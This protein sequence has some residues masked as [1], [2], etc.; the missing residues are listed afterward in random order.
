MSYRAT[1]A[2][3]RL[4]PR[5]SALLDAMGQQLDEGL[6][7]LSIYSDPEIYALELERIYGRCWV[8]LGHESEIP[9]PGDYV[10][11]TI[12]E[13]PWIVVRDDSGTVHVLFN[14]CR[15]R[16]TQVCPADQGNVSVF[17]CPY[18]GW[19]YNNAG[20]LVV[21]PE[22]VEAY[23]ALDLA[24]WGLHEAPQIDSYHGLIFACL[25]PLAPSLADYLGDFR[26]YM[27]LNFGMARAGMEVVGEPHRWVM[28]GDW[29]SGAE[30]FSGDPYHTHSLH[31]S[32][33]FVRGDSVR[34]PLGSHPNI[35]ECSGHGASII[36]S[37]P[38]QPGFFAYPP[39]VV[40]LLDPQ[41]VTPAQWDLASR[42]RFTF[43]TVFPNLSWVHSGGPDPG[44]KPGERR[45][46]YLSFRQW[47]PRGPGRIEVWSWV[48]VPKE[49]SDE[50]KE[51]SYRLAVSRFGPSGNMEQDDT[52]VWGSIARAARTTYAR[53]AQLKINL[54][55]GLEGMSEAKVLTDWPGPGLV[56][57]RELE[58]G[59]QR[60]ILRHWLAEMT[61]P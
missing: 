3:S 34:P 4:S 56:Y 48:L 38:D 30:N 25:D 44:G 35:A 16:G 54:Q 13:D 57:D 12:G 8:C 55:M 47:Q 10:L 51:R 7:P 36:M 41:K 22:R 40:S 6:V 59:S 49:A 50:Y 42:L 53:T 24:H 33:I 45:L 15:H 28:A 2:D 11:R 1:V 5:L 9:N 21:V 23:R 61:R 46:S 43:G 17:R 18:H 58:E 29:K 20:A 52:V 31:R 26:W 39:E 32:T 37:A 60:T 14:S 27:D 19:T